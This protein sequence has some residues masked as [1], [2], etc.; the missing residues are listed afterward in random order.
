MQEAHPSRTALRVAMRRAAHQMHDARPLVFDDPF[1]VPILPPDARLELKRTPAAARK[2]FSAA[3][4]AFMV[5]RARFAEDVLAAGV[6][7][8]GVRQALI[9]G[10]GLDT[11]ALRNPYP[12]VRVFEVDHPATQTWKRSLLTASKLPLPDTLTFVPVDFESQSLR[13]QLLHAGFDFALPTATAWLGVVPYLTSEAF[14]AT[15]RVLGRLP[16]GSS[17]VFD[18]SQPREALPFVEQLMLDSLSARVAQ[19]GEPFQL[20]FT[21]ERLAENLSWHNLTVVE[22]LDG[23]ALNAR[24]LANRTDGLELRGRAGRLCHAEVRSPL[25]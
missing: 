14:A 13:Q 25:S 20:F 17:L 21:P 19:A 12:N 22:D 1:A 16:A 2:P 3:L 10:A 8:R 11:F 23:P 15:A 5:C 6:R 18:Y 7:D 4:R 24:Y 9:L